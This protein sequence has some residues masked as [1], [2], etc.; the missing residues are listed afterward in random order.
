MSLHFGHSGIMVY[1][2][3]CR[4]L[5]LIEGINEAKSWVGCCRVGG[6]RAYRVLHRALKLL[7]NGLG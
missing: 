7:S 2:K 3:P 4:A 6:L 1:Q 5:V